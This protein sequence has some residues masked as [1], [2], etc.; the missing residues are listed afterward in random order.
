MF[1]D[2]FL[3]L[4]LF[5]IQVF[6]QLFL[7]GFLILFLFKC[8]RFLSVLAKQGFFY[9][10][11]CCSQKSVHSFLIV[12]LKIILYFIVENDLKIRILFEIGVLTPNLGWFTF[13]VNNVRYLCGNK[14]N[15]FNIDPQG[16]VVIPNV[17]CP[18]KT[19]PFAMLGFGSK[20]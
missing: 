18:P 6:F 5:I 7:E 19:D 13:Y 17:T 12:L 11:W 2:L 16:R 9:F 14:L 4:G 8:P 10:H 15:E 20:I 1:F 3:N